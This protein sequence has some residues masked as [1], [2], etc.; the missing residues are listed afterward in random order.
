M[1]LDGTNASSTN[2]SHWATFDNAAC[3]AY[4]MTKQSG[5]QHLIGFMLTANDPFVVIDLDNKVKNPATEEELSRY[6]KIIQIF[7]SYTELS[8]SGRG[9]HVVIKGPVGAGH[10]RDKIEVY[11]QQR[12]MVMTGDV[13]RS[14]PVHQRDELLTS[15]IAQISAKDQQANPSVL[16]DDPMPDIAE[17]G[18]VYDAASG[19]T[20]NGEKFRA[21]CTFTACEGE[22]DKK[23]HGSYIQYGYPSQSEADLA[24]ISMFWFWSKRLNDGRGSATQVVRLFQCT[25]LSKRS[26]CTESYIRR[27]LAKT[28]NSQLIDYAET[29]LEGL[30]ANE[31]AAALARL[32]QP[33]SIVVPGN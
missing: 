4:R 25:G 14:S 31:L 26:K 20:L 1:K 22:G 2:P 16:D 5:R 24:L 8:A 33:A 10:H 6:S 15:L 23:V 17:D 13:A 21:L 12:F 3:A 30:I 18:A 27:T 9:A 32:A 11:S 19:D 29:H 7:D 28:A